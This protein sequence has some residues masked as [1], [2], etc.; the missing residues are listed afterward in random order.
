[1]LRRTASP[2]IKI[3]IRFHVSHLQTEGLQAAMLE[4]RT[5]ESLYSIV[6]TLSSNMATV[7]ITQNLSI[8]LIFRCKLA[9]RVV[10]QVILQHIEYVSKMI[11]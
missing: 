5:I 11:N 7:V 3:T 10:S 4:G 2:V 8:A 9:Y 1:M 6:L